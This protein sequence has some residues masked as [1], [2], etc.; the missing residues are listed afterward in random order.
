MNE[1]PE[2]GVLPN[3]ENW[4]E[5]QVGFAPY[6]GPAEMKWFYGQVVD[7]DERDPEFVRYLIR[8]GVDTQCQRGPVEDAEEVLVKAGEYFTISVYYSLQGAFDFYLE[9]GIKPWMKV[10][11]I[12]TTETSKSGRTVWHWKLVVSPED[13]KRLNAARAQHKAMSDAGEFPPKSLS[14]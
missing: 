14:T 10:T 13:K 11:A 2:L 6:W 12:K 5:E 8:A 4:E 9:T 7:K 1:N 3:F